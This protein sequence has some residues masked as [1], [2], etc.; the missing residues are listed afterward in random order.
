MSVEPATKAAVYVAGVE[1]AAEEATQASGRVTGRAQAVAARSALAAANTRIEDVG[2]VV[3]DTTG[4]RHRFYETALA[5]TRLRPSRKQTLATVSLA[6]SLGEVGCALGALSVVY[7]A[8]ALERRWSPAKAAMYLGGSEGD[9]RT[10]V[11]LQERGIDAGH[12]LHQQ[13]KRVR[14]QLVG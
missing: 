13:P 12:R 1:L 2:L 6:S 7:A 10:A 9:L 3:N 11:V 4:M 5:V 14:H 8:F